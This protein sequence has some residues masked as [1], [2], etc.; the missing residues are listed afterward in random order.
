L[1][2]LGPRD[3]GSLGGRRRRGSALSPLW[4]T[5]RCLSDR[6]QRCRH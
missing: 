4:R 3:R 2:D 1:A 5:R 6:C